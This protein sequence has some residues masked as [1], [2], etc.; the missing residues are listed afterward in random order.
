MCILWYVDDLVITGPD[1]AAI[2]KVKSQLS[3]AFEMKD[4]VDL[5][6]F[7]RIEVIHTHDNILLSQRHYVLNMLYKFGMTDCRPVSTPQGVG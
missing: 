7:L 2:S 3:K 1:L 5:H 4:L 6:Y